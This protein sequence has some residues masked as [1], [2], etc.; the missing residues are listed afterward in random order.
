M[1]KI[2]K[3]GEFI[4]K[5][6]LSVIAVCLVMITAKLYIPEAEADP[7]NNEFNAAV[8]EAMKE[9]ISSIYHEIK[10]I[11]EELSLIEEQINIADETNNDSMTDITSSI[12]FLDKE[13]RKLWDQGYKRNKVNILK[14]TKRTSEIENILSN[15]QNDNG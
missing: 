13:I 14:L 7:T 3:E 12:Q 15:L 5:F 8:K 2:I 9:D 4:M 1:I 11:D 6:L 10:L